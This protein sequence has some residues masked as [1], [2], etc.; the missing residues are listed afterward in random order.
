MKKPVVNAILF[1]LDGTLADTAP[2]LVGAINQ[3]L[4]EDNLPL[5]PIDELR[6]FVS[7]GSLGLIPAAFGIEPPHQSFEALK[8][9]FLTAYKENICVQ[10]SL[11]DG[12]RPLLDQLDACN[13]PWGIVTNKNRKL[14]LTL[15]K[16]LGLSDT[17]CVVCGDDMIRAKPWP[18]T[19]LRAAELLNIAPREIIYVG[20]YHRDIEAAQAANMPS[21]GVTYGYACPEIPIDTWGASYIINHPD[22]LYQIIWPGSTDD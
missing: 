7:R 17:Q 3:L 15:L 12:I 4:K 10:T 13:M 8:D 20:D 11:F 19:L 5:R 16:A 6:P 22:E 14:T 21:V 2:D 1:D 18:D 9:R